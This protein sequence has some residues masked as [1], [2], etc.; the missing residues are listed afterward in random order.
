M[1]NAK[2]LWQGACKCSFA[3]ASLG[4]AET[5]PSAPCK[6][7]LA[8]W[9]LL[10]A[11]SW[12]AERESK[13]NTGKSLVMLLVAACAAGAWAQSSVVLEK[14][15]AKVRDK[16]GREGAVAQYLK[17]AEQR[18]KE[19]ESIYAKKTNDDLEIDENFSLG[20]EDDIMAGASAA[21]DSR[22]NDAEAMHYLSAAIDY[23]YAARPKLAD[24]CLEHAE[25]IKGLS[26]KV[27]DEI[28][29]EKARIARDRDPA[30]TDPPPYAAPQRFKA[31]AE[32]R[33]KLREA[34]SGNATADLLADLW[35]KIG[36]ESFKAFDPAG[37]REAQSEVAK[38][39]RKP[40]CYAGWWLN[41]VKAFDSFKTFPVA[42]SEIV[43]PKDLSAFGVADTRTIIAG[44]LD[45]DPEDATACLR[46]AIESGATTIV[47]EDHGSPWYVQT[48]VPKSNQRILLKKGVKVL[49]DAT[50]RQLRSKEPMIKLA[51][52][53]NV[54]I[55]GEGGP[56][57]V[58]IGKFQSLDERNKFSAD[59]GGSGVLFEGC[60]NIV[61]RNVTLGANTMDGATLSGIGGDTRN[62]YLDN[63]VLKDNYR[64]AMSVCN[65][66]GLYCRKVSFI[67]TVGGDPM[68]GIDFESEYESE[69]NTDMYFFDCVFGGNAGASVNFSESSYFPV[70]ALFKRCTFNQNRNHSQ[71]TV[72]PR[73]GVYM[74]ANVKAPSRIIF[75]DCEM[76]VDARNAS[77]VIIANSCL[78]DVV[79]RNFRLRE[80]PG[81]EPGKGC[82]A[83][84]QVKLDR[85][86]RYVPEWRDFKPE[87]EG[88][89]T[90][91]NFNVEGFSGGPILSVRDSTG[92]YSVEN[93]SG[94]AEFNGEKIDMSAFAY[95]APEKAMGL[96]DIAKFSPGDYV[97]PA[98]GAR[99][100]TP[101]A[102]PEKFRFAWKGQWFESPSAYR[103]IYAKDGEWRMR[104]ITEGLTELDAE[105]LPVAYYCR[106]LESKAKLLPVKNGEPY[107]I[108]FE[109]PAGGAECVMKVVWGL[110]TLRN[111]AGE[112]VAETKWDEAGW[113]TRYLKMKPSSDKAEIWSLTFSTPATVKF[114][115]PLNGV[116][117]EHPEN[118]P[119]RK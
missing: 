63:V 58:Y 72:F 27:K 39:K 38:L 111:A 21:A 84:V 11:D 8:A 89:L 79:F 44:E 91:D 59:Y 113:S 98:A 110:G 118:L 37:M 86:Y 62:I 119:R 54:V 83:P 97:P 106:S 100:A 116:F 22:Q 96:A 5:L 31:L 48:I 68:A 24:K 32:A 70:T 73:C 19:A 67:D 103:A 115:A 12:L 64:Q 46:E 74:G 14:E 2:A 9:R 56:D 60:E 82:N 85:E 45:W 34:Q 29:K 51:G 78:F 18:M 99:A 6:K 105:G 104:K 71:I 41:A 36:F 7:S 102:L 93:I 80:L 17:A 95:P 50:S 23:D 75:E 10:C 26:Q 25:S 16:A 20:D 88:S 65:A 15:A 33:A 55:E 109:L 112:V 30:E 101:A 66:F 53:K 35:S 40:G 94:V 69:A 28:A 114:F 90:F 13:V 108:Y 117:A 57:D 61:V 43:F 81:R 87:N 4:M 3:F 52:V 47:L 42:E 77:P 76:A 107:T 49:M 92:G 1:E